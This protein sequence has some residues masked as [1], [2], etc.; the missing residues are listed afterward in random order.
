MRDTS[1]YE[2]GFGAAGTPLAAAVAATVAWYWTWQPDPHHG[3]PGVPIRP[4]RRGR[5]GAEAGHYPQSQQPDM[6]TG[7]IQRFLE[8]VTSPCLTATLAQAQRKG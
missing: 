4:L 7:A 5:H 1:R 2:S 3:I 6:T 8:S